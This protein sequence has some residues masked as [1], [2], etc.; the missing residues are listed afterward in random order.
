MWPLALVLFLRLV[1]FGPHVHSHL[2]WEL[3]Q[4]QCVRVATFYLEFH[5]IHEEGCPSVASVCY[6][7]SQ[8]W[9]SDSG[10]LKRSFGS[11]L[12][13]VHHW[14]PSRMCLLLIGSLNFNRA[15]LMW[16]SCPETEL[17][18][19]AGYVDK[20]C[21]ILIKEWHVYVL[22]I[23]IAVLI[24]AIC[25]CCRKPALWLFRMIKLIKKQKKC[26]TSTKKYQSSWV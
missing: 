17:V 24:E 19:K 9:Q 8:C 6:S 23:S 1:P 11:L 22:G 25:V 20:S 12:S 7:T 10:E 4:P 14:R 3:D 16:E 2:H 26:Y 18:V 5:A 13:I 15:K 21:N